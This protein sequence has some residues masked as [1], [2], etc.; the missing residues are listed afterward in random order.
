MTI[1]EA[2]IKYRL[3]TI[4]S[5][6]ILAFLGIASFLIM[7]RAEDP[8]IDMPLIATAIIYPGATPMDIEKQVV[9]TIESTLNELEEVKFI[10]SNIKENVAMILTEFDYGV[11]SDEKKEKVEAVINGLQ[12]ELPDGIQSIRKGFHQNF[13]PFI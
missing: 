6:V 13:N 7:P 12:G 5:M 10:T 11:D 4:M 8:A 1:S 9:E 2:A 3:F